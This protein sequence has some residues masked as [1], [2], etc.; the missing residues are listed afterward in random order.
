MSNIDEPQTQSEEGTEKGP[1]FDELLE[2]LRG[3]FPPH[4]VRWRLIQR[5]RDGQRNG[6]AVAYV[7]MTDVEDFLDE[8]MGPARWKA[9][10]PVVGQFVI[11]RIELKDDE[12]KWI[13]KEDGSGDNV[14]RDAQNA[15]DEDLDKETKA[16]LSDSFKR[17]AR[18]W[19]IGRYLAS[20]DKPWV[21]CVPVGRSFVI[22]D[23]E[24]P[25]L[26]QLAGA[27]PGVAGYAPP[28][29]PAQSQA[30]TQ[31]HQPQQQQ[32]QQHQ[33]QRGGDDIPFGGQD[34]GPPP[35][36][37]G[38]Y[39]GDRAPVSPR[40]QHAAPPQQ[41]APR[42][43]QG[44]SQGAPRVFTIPAGR[45]KG[46]PLNEAE[47]KDILYWIDKKANE[48]DPRFARSNQEWVA[49]ANAELSRRK[50][51]SGQ[52]PQGPP[53]SPPGDRPPPVRGGYQRTSQQ[54]PDDYPF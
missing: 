14:D 17:A 45:A 15:T 43:N 26:A 21:E 49:A 7:S 37:R 13:G 39:G 29:Q 31:Q 6:K 53:A 8:I 1:S 2:Q 11:C 54:P 5:P 47:E 50:G 10:Y 33:P 18:R 42:Q 23:F 34:N 19:G 36:Q 25:R 52:A 22:A 51:A 20:L 48:N 3:N 40:Q 28:A 30:P 24:Y 38:G 12:G 41:Q 4:W 27:P 46:T 35:A 9:S 16:V 44:Q 32:A